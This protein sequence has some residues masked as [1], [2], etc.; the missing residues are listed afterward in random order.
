[1]NRHTPAFNGCLCFPARPTL[2]SIVY[3]ACS[4]R[5][6]F[7]TTTIAVSQRAGSL[8]SNIGVPTLPVITFIVTI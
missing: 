6:I 8:S 2:D 7:S 3:S 4:S 5:M 1:M